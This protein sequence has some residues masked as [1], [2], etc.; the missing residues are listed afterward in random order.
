MSHLILVV[1]DQSSMR[2]LARV[3]LVRLG[4]RVVTAED[5]PTAIR[6][7]ETTE[8]FALILLDFAMPVMSG[9]EMLGRI[10]QTR[11]AIRA[12]VSSGNVERDLLRQFEGIP[13]SGYI[14]KP[15]SVR[16]LASKIKQ[17]LESQLVN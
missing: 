8:D 12:L 11:P 4:Y 16:Q 17:I 1:D 7:C 6:L 9:A 3:S 2:E 10:R 15:Y 13:I 14:Q 5:G